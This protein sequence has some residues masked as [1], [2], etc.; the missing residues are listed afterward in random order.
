[1]KLDRVGPDIW[2]HSAQF[3]NHLM[4]F[5]FFFCIYKKLGTCSHFSSAEVTSRRHIPGDQVC[6]WKERFD[7]TSD[8]GESQVCGSA[9]KGLR[10]ETEPLVFAQL[11]MCVMGT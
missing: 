6:F 11:S 2:A 4:G 3:R 9:E 8:S 1:M 10:K 5:F 7:G